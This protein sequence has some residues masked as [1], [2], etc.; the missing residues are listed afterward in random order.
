M[1]KE[2]VKYPVRLQVAVPSI[3]EVRKCKLLSKRNSLPFG[4]WTWK[5]YMSFQGW[6]KL[7][8]CWLDG[9]SGGCELGHICGK[10]RSGQIHWILKYLVHIRFVQNK[11]KAFINTEGMLGDVSSGFWTTICHYEE[12]FLFKFLPNC[13]HLLIASCVYFNV[14]TFIF[15]KKRIL[16][17]IYKWGKFYENNFNRLLILFP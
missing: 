12:F 2:L 15:V 11:S 14:S 8:A 9:E 3:F 5:N 1:Q 4:K 16:C 13:A 7:I 10:W 17:F 6:R